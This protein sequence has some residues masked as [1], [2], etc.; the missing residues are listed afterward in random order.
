MIDRDTFFICNWSEGIWRPGRAIH[1]KSAQVVCG[2][3][4]L[5]AQN[6]L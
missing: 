4:T 2:G 1:S 6:Q 3:V 5:S